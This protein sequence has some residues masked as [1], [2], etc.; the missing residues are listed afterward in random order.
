MSL[1]LALMGAQF[2]YSGVKSIMGH[3]QRQSQYR[4]QKKQAKKQ[5]AAR[6]A[7]LQAGWMRDLERIADDNKAA[8]DA[9]NATIN[10]SHQQ[11]G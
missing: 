1:T 7:E 2:A 11:I 6:N 4:A 10:Q 8:Y 5:A 9:F 3:S